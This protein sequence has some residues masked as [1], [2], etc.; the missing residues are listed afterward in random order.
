MRRAQTFP[1]EEPAEKREPFCTSRNVGKGL[2]VCVIA[3]LDPERPSIYAVYIT[4][5]W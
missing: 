1:P 5:L 3:I 4:T 2:K